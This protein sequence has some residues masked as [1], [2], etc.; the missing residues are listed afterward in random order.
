M[1]TFPFPSLHFE[2]SLAREEV[3]FPQGSQLS[4]RPPLLQLPT[5]EWERG[6]YHLH[7]PFCGSLLDGFFYSF[8]SL[9]LSTW[10]GS[11]FIYLSHFCA[12]LLSFCARVSNREPEKVREFF[13]KREGVKD[14]GKGEVREKNR[15]RKSVLAAKRDIGLRVR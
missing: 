11:R 7:R 4:P 2:N 13:T 6:K 12:S 15:V 8:L 14:W 10:F 3:R 1:R 5:N 9:F